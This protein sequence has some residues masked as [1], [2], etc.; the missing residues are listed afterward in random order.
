MKACVISLTT[1]V[2]LYN[3]SCSTQQI[4][5][6]RETKFIVQEFLLEM[7]NFAVTV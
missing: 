3:I 6:D 5:T 7:N 2:K 4:A 1:I